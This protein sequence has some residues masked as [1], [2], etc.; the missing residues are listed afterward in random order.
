MGQNPPAGAIIDYYLSQAAEGPVTI[1]ILDAK[2]QVVRKFSSNDVPELTP[3]QLNKQ[4]IPVYWVRMPEN[5]GTT[6]GMHRFIWDLRYPSPTSVTHEYPI[7]A[8]P[9]NTPRY[10][11]GPHALPGS[12]TVRLSVNGKSYTA[13]L[14]VKLD[15]RV[16]TAQAALEQMF[17]VEQ[18][19][20]T[21][22]S[23]SS[24]AVF[25]AK[26]LQEQMEKLKPTGDVAGALKAFQ[27]KVSTALD[28]PENHSP[29][30]PKPPTLSDVN[31]SAYDLY[32]NVSQVNA[33][34]TAAQVASASKTEE[35]LATVLA[36]WAQVIK[37]DLPAVN[38]QLKQ[39]GLP[40]L[41]PQQKPE[42]GENQRNEE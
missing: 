12:Y 29:N 36:Q 38:V 25:Q 31:G 37:T 2:N 40:E 5:P 15:P 30:A 11:L 26:S 20:S 3:E 14:T 4:L 21:A 42:S 32:K 7:T 1:E 27:A 10:P 19:L 23:R 24:E 22:V 16:K 18:R 9:G 6:A 33:S 39:A 35:D 17:A 41:N 8:V 13:P 28:G 34:P